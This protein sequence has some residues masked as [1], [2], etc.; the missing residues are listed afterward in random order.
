MK[1]LSPVLR[2]GMI[3]VVVIAISVAYAYR[4]QLFP[5]FYQQAG[6][7]DESTES[8]SAAVTETPAPVTD[9]SVS[10]EEPAPAAVASA[11]AGSAPAGSAPAGS[12]PAGS[13]PVGSAPVGSAPVGSAPAGSAPAGSAPVGSAPAGSAPHHEMRANKMGQKTI[14]TAPAAPTAPAVPSTP[15]VSTIPPVPSRHSAPATVEQAPAPAASASAPDAKTLQ[16][17]QE[18]MKNFYLIIN[19]AR[20]A[21]WQAQFDK[22][23]EYYQ[24]AIRLMPAIPD[25]YGELGNIY[26]GQGKWEKAG[27]SYYQAAVRLLDEKRVAKAYHLMTILRGLAPERAEALQKKANEMSLK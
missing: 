24:Q 9:K 4:E 7:Q 21:Y 2:H 25:T 1:W 6:L 5:M 22:A 18:A 8:G 15:T 19:N 17:D 20:Q 23:E 16:A 11:P 26:Y 10:T 14:E 12:A 13:A 3:I 27:E